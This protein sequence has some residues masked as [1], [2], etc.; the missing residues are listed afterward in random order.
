MIFNRIWVVFDVLKVD[1]VMF[2]LYF[3]EIVVLV[4][5][6]QVESGLVFVN[7]RKIRESEELVYYVYWSCF[8]F[9]YLS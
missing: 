6:F 3:F 4:Y 8:F 2:E 5:D 7:N 9:R 1:V